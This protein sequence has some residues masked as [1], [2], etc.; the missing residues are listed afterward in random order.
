M[1]PSLLIEYRIERFCGYVSHIALVVR[2]Y[3]HR[4]SIIVETDEHLYKIAFQASIKDDITGEANLHALII[5]RRLLL[6][7]NQTP[8][9]SPQ[10]SI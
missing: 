8:T 10:C 4:G 2:A 6:I 9:V 1:F 3:L 5:T 7:E